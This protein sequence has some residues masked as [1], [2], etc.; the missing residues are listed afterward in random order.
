MIPEYPRDSLPEVYR[1]AI[2][3]KKLSEI[4]D[5]FPIPSGT[6]GINKFVIA[7]I[8]FLG[9]AGE[10]TLDEMRERIRSQLSEERSMR[11]LIDTLK[12]PLRLNV[13]ASSTSS[14]DDLSRQQNEPPCTQMIAGRFVTV[15]PVG[16]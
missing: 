4:L 7:Q 10:Y 8:T 12:K 5:P 15:S 11:R 13:P 16:W 9:D 3:G 2:E 14:G 6:P 1:N